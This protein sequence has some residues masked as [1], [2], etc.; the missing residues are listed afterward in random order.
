MVGHDLRHPAGEE[1]GV[2]GVEE[3]AVEDLRE[4]LGPGDRLVEPVQRRI[5]GPQELGEVE[6]L[7]V[8]QL[9]LSDRIGPR[10]VPGAD[11]GRL[12]RAAAFPPQ[13]D[14]QQ[15]SR[16]QDREP[17]APFAEVLERVQ[18]LGAFLDLVE[19][20]DVR[21]DVDPCSGQCRELR[22]D[23]LR[24]LRVPEESR[25]PLLLV[26]VELVH[27][28]EVPL[29]ELPHQ[30]GLSNLPR[31]HQDE[32]LPIRPVLPG[33]QALFDI[34]LHS[35]SSEYRTFSHILVRKSRQICQFLT[36]LQD[37]R[38]VFCQK[39]DSAARLGGLARRGG[40]FGKAAPRRAVALPRPRGAEGR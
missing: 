13:P 18:R 10:G 3:L 35:F 22:Q 1:V 4:R 16:R 36:T 7:H 17:R 30:P 32:R 28:G 40:E 38:A 31:P 19:D 6:R 11:P 37:G 39:G 2:V 20:D 5:A 15:A 8:Q 26:E 21:A 33:K 23:V 29:S 12:R 34:P 24:L 27:A 14:A 25:Q 9:H